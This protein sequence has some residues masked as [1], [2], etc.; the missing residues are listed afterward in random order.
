[1]GDLKTKTFKEIWKNGHYKEF[2]KKILDGRKNIDI[3]A[4]C[5]EGISVWQN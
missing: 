4:N 5:S 2:R 3:C 1:M